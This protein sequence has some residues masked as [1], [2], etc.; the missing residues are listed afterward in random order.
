[1]LLFHQQLCP[2]IFAQDI[3]YSSF[4][5]C[6]F[7]HTDCSEH[8]VFAKRSICLSTLKYSLEDS[9][10]SF[11]HARFDS[12]WSIIMIRLCWYL[13]L[14]IIS[15]FLPRFPFP[16]IFHRVTFVSFLMKFGNLFI[17]HYKI[18]ISFNQNNFHN[19]CLLHLQLLLFHYQYLY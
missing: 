16:I 12:M 11:C 19:H 10:E 1:M 13:D 8:Q 14:F 7:V 17:I 3:I 4:L 18:S 2:S 15:H 9:V 5:S 6:I